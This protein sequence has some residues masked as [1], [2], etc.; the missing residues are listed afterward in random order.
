ML[1]LRGDKGSATYVQQRQA[2]A[3]ARLV[4]EPVLRERLARA[5]L[6]RARAEFSLQGMITQY[7]DLYASAFR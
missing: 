4:N 1:S 2:V 5:S 3:L 6:A 7:G